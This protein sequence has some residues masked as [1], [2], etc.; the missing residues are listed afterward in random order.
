MSVTEDSSFSRFAE[1]F[2]S[3]YWSVTKDG[4]FSMPP[5]EP[6]E[7][8]LKELLQDIEYSC[9]AKGCGYVLTMRETTENWSWW[10]FGFVYRNKSWCI[11][12]ASTRSLD[13]S[14]PHDLLSPPYDEYF[15]AFL[16]HVTKLANKSSWANKMHP[17]TDQL[18]S[19]IAMTN[20][21]TTQNLSTLSGQQLVCFTLV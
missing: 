4:L 8:S 2:V 5:D 17:T 16:E 7:E 11:K 13:K 14:I 20:L 10:K 18:E 3:A 19:P 12:D 9:Q 1:N 6:V 15:K 21:T